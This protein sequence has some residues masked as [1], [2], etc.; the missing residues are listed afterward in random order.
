MLTDIG[1]SPTDAVEFVL[2][3]VAGSLG[4]FGLLRLH[5]TEAS[6]ILLL[7][8][9]RIAR[10]LGRRRPFTV[11]VSVCRERRTQ[12]RSHPCIPAGTTPCWN[13]ADRLQLARPAAT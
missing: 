2:R 12:C 13:A 9:L 8:A 7:N 1:R 4:F 5:W 11:S 6:L 10:S 3:G